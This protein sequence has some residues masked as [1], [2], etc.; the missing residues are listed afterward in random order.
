MRSETEWVEL[1][2]S[3][4]AAIADA[5]EVEI[6]KAFE[7]FKKTKKFKFP[8]LFGDGNAAEFICEEI[9]KNIK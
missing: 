1:V 3:G 6:I 2:N 7:K 8:E 4:S 9:L 5:N